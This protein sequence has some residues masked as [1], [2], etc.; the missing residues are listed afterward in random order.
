MSGLQDA[1]VLEIDPGLVLFVVIW[2]GTHELFC[3]ADAGRE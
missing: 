2:H 3:W 1:M